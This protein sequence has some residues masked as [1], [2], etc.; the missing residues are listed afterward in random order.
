MAPSVRPMSDLRCQWVDRS[1]NMSICFL[2]S[3][4]VMTLT[5]SL[6]RH[7]EQLALQLPQPPSLTPTSS[8]S[9]GSLSLSAQYPNE[10]VYFQ[11]QVWHTICNSHRER[12]PEFPDRHLSL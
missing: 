12:G 6:A 3:N 11:R 10:G 7:D 8:S 1:I 5:R 2:S 9:F 4:P